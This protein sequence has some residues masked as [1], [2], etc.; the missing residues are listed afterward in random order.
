MARF[1][2]RCRRSMIP[3][4]IVLSILPGT[5]RAGELPAFPGVED[6]IRQADTVQAPAVSALQRRLMMLEGALAVGH[7]PCTGEVRL[8][9][10]RG[11]MV[12]CVQFGLLGRLQP[13]L[14]SM[15]QASPGLFAF[16]LG[17]HVEAVRAML[18]LPTTEAQVAWA[19]SIADG[20]SNLPG[21]WRLAFVTLADMPE[22]Q[23]AYLGSTTTRYE[24]GVRWAKDYGFQSRRGLAMMFD[25]SLFRGISADQEAALMAIMRSP[26]LMGDGDAPELRRLHAFAEA[27]D[28]MEADLQLRFHL[29]TIAAGRA[30][31]LGYALDLAAFGTT[32][33]PVGE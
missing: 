16:A 8:D 13:V 7:L 32:L 24:R 1:P 17:S 15:D 10:P 33:E 21:T 11:L 30:D 14:Q 6:A 25:L 20:E 29:A 9:R 2:H 27:R 19:H 26:D 5:A 12:G 23:A 28:G 3:L 4:L 22:F 31:F 18:R